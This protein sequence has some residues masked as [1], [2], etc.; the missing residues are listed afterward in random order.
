MDEDRRWKLLELERANGIEK[1]TVHRILRNE[2]H[3]R[4]IAAR[5]VPH[6]L[7]E[8][9]RWLRYAICFDPFARRNR[10]AINSGHEKSPSMDFRPGHTNQK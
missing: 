4:K 2:Q 9:Q 6:A 7:T 1:R 8:V 10:T 3:L 5:W